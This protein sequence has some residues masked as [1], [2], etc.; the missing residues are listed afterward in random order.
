M[1]TALCTDVN[2]VVSVK[3]MGGWKDYVTLKATEI[4]TNLVGDTAYHKLYPKY[5]ENKCKV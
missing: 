4:W 3:F 5:E 2:V 1:A